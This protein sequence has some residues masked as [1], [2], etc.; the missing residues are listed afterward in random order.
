MTAKEYN[1]LAGIFLIAH[2]FLQTFSIVLLLIIFSTNIGG[3]SGEF[4]KMLRNDF[5]QNGD[6]ITSTF[7]VF[8]I[9]VVIFTIIFSFIFIIPQIL[10]GWK[11]L[12]EKTNARTWGIIGGILAC[13]SFPF[14]T[15]AGIYVLWFLFTDIGKNFHMA[16]NANHEMF[17]NIPPPQNF[18]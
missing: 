16:N 1:R 8:M 9:L 10:G 7:G 13:L 4:Q 6:V 17:E 5:L 15:A 3:F 12:K 14:G 18:A 11:L 2:G